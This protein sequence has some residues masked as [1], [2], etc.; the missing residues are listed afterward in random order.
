MSV[1]P[2][3]VQSP[4]AVIVENK[5]SDIPNIIFIV[6]K[7]SNFGINKQILKLKYSI[8]LTLAFAVVGVEFCLL[9]DITGLLLL[10]LLTDKFCTL[11]GCGII[12][13]SSFIFSC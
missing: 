8:F 11:G 2:L 12:V 13:I 3:C 4:W 9:A 1:P 5:N 10:L 7:Y 6:R